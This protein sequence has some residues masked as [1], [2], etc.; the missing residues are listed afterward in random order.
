M[1]KVSQREN[2]I[3][4]VEY[5]AHARIGL[6][7]VKSAYEDRMAICQEPH[8]I[9]SIIHGISLITD[10]AVEFL[11]SPEHTEMI[12]ANAIVVDSKSGYY[13]HDNNILWMLKN[14]DK[15]KVNVEV[16]DNEESAL[17]WLS[18]YL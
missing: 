5:P 4:V 3:L 8:C 10:E 15:P 16:F 17:E 6:K 18:H 13:E 1:P 9:L 7:D 2:G 11:M 14:I 12:K